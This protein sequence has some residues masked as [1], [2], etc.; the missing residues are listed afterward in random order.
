MVLVGSDIPTLDAT[1]VVRAFASL[2]KNDLVIGPCQDGGYYLIGMKQ[3]HPELFEGIIWSTSLVLQQTIQ[4]ARTAELEIV[5]LEKKSDIDTYVEELWN[6]LKKRNMK[7]I[8]SFKSKTYEVLK[9][10]F[11]TEYAASY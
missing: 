7:G 4:K 1:T 3:P 6:F 5:Q 10:F 9:T 8:Y 2:D 11:E